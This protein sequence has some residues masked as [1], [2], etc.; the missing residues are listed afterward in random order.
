MLHLFLLMLVLNRIHLAYADKFDPNKCV[1]DVQKYCEQCVR[2]CRERVEEVKHKK[3]ENCE[4]GGAV[5]L[6]DSGTHRVNCICK[7][8]ESF[9]IGH[10]VAPE[11]V[12]MA[13]NAAH[14]Y[15]KIGDNNNS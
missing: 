5:Q 11:A 12:R 10:C 14:K 4:G 13:L 9:L 8:R 15:G 3:K 2:I 1:A 7:W 6:T